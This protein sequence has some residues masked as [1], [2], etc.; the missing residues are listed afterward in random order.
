MLHT[1]L[2]SLAVASRIS[3]VPPVV[4]PDSVRPDIDVRLVALR[5]AGEIQ[6]CYETEGLRVNP[7]LGGMIEVEIT[8]VPS[9]R[10]EEAAVSSS[11]LSG[12]GHHEVET[13]ITSS[14]RNWRFERGPFAVETIVFPFNL[15]RDRGVISNTRT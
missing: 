5:H 15:V 3:L 14:I 8:V 12:V 6:H 10:V 13:C 2:F 1:L 9:G 7:G 4:E 11:N